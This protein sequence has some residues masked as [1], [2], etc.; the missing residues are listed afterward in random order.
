MVSVSPYSVMVATAASCLEW[1]PTDT[2]LF[3]TFA[4]AIRASAVRLSL[5][6]MLC[7]QPSVEQK[8]STT[9]AAET[10]IADEM[11]SFAPIDSND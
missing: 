9:D 2:A 8:Q 10:V 11:C 3:A 6:E 4:R 1:K 7:S 5:C